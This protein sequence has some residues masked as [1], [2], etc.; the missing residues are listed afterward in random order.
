MNRTILISAIGILALLLSQAYWLTNMYLD[1]IAQYTDLIDK[2]LSYSIDNE[3]ILQSGLFGEYN[4]TNKPK[5]IIKSADEMTPEE[6]KSHKGDTIVLESDSSSHT[7][8]GISTLFAQSSIDFF[9]KEHSFPMTVLDSI[10]KNEIQKNIPHATYQLKLCSRKEQTIDSNHRIY[11]ENQQIITITHPIGTKEEFYIQAIVAIPPQ[12]IFLHLFYALIVSFLMTII[13]LYC[14]YYQ[15]IVIRNTRKRLLQQQQAIHTAIHDLKAPLNAAYSIL[16]FIALKETDNNRKPLLQT[17]KMQIR[18]LTGIIESILNVHKERQNIEIKKTQ[19]FLPE[20][21]EEA[22]REI[23]LLF[24]GKK[25]RFELD[26]PTSIRYIHTDPIRLE[27]CLRNLLENAL[28]YSDDNVKITVSLSKHDNCF[29]IAIQDT[30]WGIPLKAQ[31]KLGKQFYRVQ[32]TGKEV[33]PGYGLGLCSVKQLVK[34]MDG[35]FTFR[36]TEGTGSVFVITL[37]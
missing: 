21:I 30:G 12:Q 10:F 15:L 24:P 29:S 34:E 4:R 35:S 31:K 25:Y 22:N 2:S 16:D 11:K 32:A 8:K 33:Q 9:L 23:A 27:R 6:I 18:K 36:S 14:L 28:K 37:P 1:K 20:L 13:I 5:L 26:N 7:R 17:G 19:V 3:L